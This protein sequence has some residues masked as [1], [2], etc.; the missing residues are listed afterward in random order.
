VAVIV[1]VVDLV[2]VSEGIGERENEGVFE[3]VVVGVAE[4]VEATDEVV[5]GVAKAVFVD[6]A[7]AIEEKVPCSKPGAELALLV[8]VIDAVPVFVA[9]TDDV[10]DT[11]D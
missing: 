1:V 7:D 8:V 2:A 6:D 3:E 5:V 11:V 9:E 4:T 10:G